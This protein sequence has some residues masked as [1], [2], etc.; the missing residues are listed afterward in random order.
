M[1]NILMRYDNYKLD[2]RRGVSDMC[3][4]LKSWLKKI[5]KHTHIQISRLSIGLSINEIFFKL[6]KAN[7]V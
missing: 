4:F 7:P 3:A 2:Q 5:C 6:K 1:K